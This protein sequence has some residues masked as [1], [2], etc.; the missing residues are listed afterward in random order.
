MELERIRSAVAVGLEE[1]DRGEWFSPEEV[2]ADLLT[3]DKRD[4][5]TGAKRTSEVRLSLIVLAS[6]AQV[7]ERAEAG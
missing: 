4:H 7:A 6:V 3:S 2:F 1:L 5:G